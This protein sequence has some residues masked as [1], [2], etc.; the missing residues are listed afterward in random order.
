MNKETLIK[1]LQA[2]Y[3]QRELIVANLNQIDG[4]IIYLD[5]KIKDLAKTSIDS[6]EEKA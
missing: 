4:V 5:A 2:A 3:K 1:E 6:K